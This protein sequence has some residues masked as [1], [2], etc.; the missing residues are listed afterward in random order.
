MFSLIL[1][2]D[3]VIC[4]V[5]VH[6]ANVFYELGI[7]HSL[8]KK[9]TILIKGKPTSDQIPF[10]LLTDRYLTYDIDNP[11][12]SK[13]DLIAMI[14][15][16][17][18]SDQ[19]TDSPVFRM[20]PTLAEADPATLQIVP[21]DFREEVERAQT[22]K[23]KGWLRLLAQDVLGLRFQHSGLQLIAK[24]QWDLGDYESAK[25]SLEII[26]MIYPD[27]I[28]VNLMLANIYERLSRKE[29]LPELLLASDQ[30]IARVLANQ[31]LD[32][33]KAVEA[34]TLKGRNQKTQWRLEFAGLGPVER[35]REVA[36]N[37]AL[38]SSYDAYRAAFNQ[39]LNHFWSGLASLQMGTIFLELSGEDNASWKSHFDNDDQADSYRSK[40]AKDV[41]SLKLLVPASVVAKQVQMK[42]SDPNQAWAEISKAD[43]LFLTEKAEQRVLNRYKD[44]I[45]KDNVFAWNAAKGQLELFAGLGIKSEL[46]AKVIEAIESRQSEDGPQQEENKIPAKPVHTIIFAGHRTDLPGRDQTRFPTDRVAQARDLIRKALNE[47]KEG[48]SVLGF[49][50]AAP[51]ADLLFQEICTEEAIPSTVCLPIP[52]D[53][54]APII[55][56]EFSDWLSRFLDLM[57]THKRILEL[58]DREGLPHWLS[59][60]KTDPW[61][62]GNRWVM[63]MAQ[64]TGA[65]KLTLIALWDGKEE[66]DAPGGTAHMIELA[67]E[68]GNVRLK[69]INTQELL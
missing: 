56:G 12:D 47:S 32:S 64:A 53:D 23:S 60:A 24:A 44:V 29:N 51:G 19:E 22:V 26:R 20:L 17:M 40:L 8:R 38:R 21:V 33:E 58:S 37:S 35:C 6:N 54:Y 36:M 31:N 65:D 27:H 15:A 50:S 16:T 41:E 49:S 43:I 2:A 62:R 68:A 5:T 39:D 67:R 14:N 18:R 63:Q 1:E 10:D 11:G 7:R 28:E 25:E 48:Y 13:T 61:E 59:G 30:A 57:Q 34:L 4:D 9:R 52:K 42:Q 66:G 46:A 55:F 3:I 69:I 45:P